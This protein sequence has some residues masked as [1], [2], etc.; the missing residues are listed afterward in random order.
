[1][2][3]TEQKTNENKSRKKS[4][5]TK[6]SKKRTL[7]N[8]RAEVAMEHVAIE[9][10]FDLSTTP[11]SKRKKKTVTMIH[12]GIESHM[13]T[14]SPS[15]S[16]DDVFVPESYQ[17]TKK[18]KRQTKSRDKNATLTK[19]ATQPVP[20]ST[21][22]PQSKSLKSKSK[23]KSKTT[24]KAFS[25][26]SYPSVIP[27]QYAIVTPKT[28]ALSTLTRIRV[29][30]TRNPL[31]TSLCQLGSKNFTMKELIDCINSQ[32]QHASSK[33]DESDPNHL[34]SMHYDI[35]ATEGV[36]CLSTD[37]TQMALLDCQY[38]AF[39]YLDIHSMVETDSSESICN[40]CHNKGELLLCDSCPH[41]F[42]LQCVGLEQFPTTP[43]WRT[44][45]FELPSP[46]VII[47]FGFQTFSFFF[48]FFSFLS[49]SSSSSSKVAFSHSSNVDHK[50]FVSLNTHTN[51]I[52]YILKWQ[53]IYPLFVKPP[54]IAFSAN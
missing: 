15:C 11:R 34:Q 42:H 2:V 35:T 29:K 18:S 49:F 52:T 31:K 43:K 36:Y 38:N 47:N 39:E 51:N 14:P 6:S 25:S 24:F 27:Y 17:S 48:F 7:N 37:D 5:Q 30:C 45:M 20:K 41:A 40:L 1:M 19:M 23:S 22:K 10:E 13:S 32:Q 8:M 9:G 16:S 46:T 54:V 12:K 33:I 4:A 26:S 3:T 44:K 50:F 21:S 28:E 53:F